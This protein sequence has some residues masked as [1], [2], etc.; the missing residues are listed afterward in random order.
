MSDNTNTVPSNHN[1]RLPGH[2]L[3]ANEYKQLKA[4]RG[5]GRWLQVL[6]FIP[7]IIGL[8]LIIFVFATNI[9]SAF[10]WFAI[11]S[12][13]RG[14]SSGELFPVDEVS[15]DDVIRHELRARGMS[16]EEIDTFFAD[17][18][19]FADYAT[20][21]A[22]AWEGLVAEALERD[23]TRL[24][25]ENNFFVERAN[26]DLEDTFAN[27][28]TIVAA[29]EPLRDTSAASSSLAEIQAALE[30]LSFPEID[31]LSEQAAT[32][33]SLLSNTWQDAKNENIAQYTEALGAI[34]EQANTLLDSTALSNLSTLRSSYKLAPLINSDNLGRFVDAAQ[35]VAD[36][37]LFSSSATLNIPLQRFIEEVHIIR[38]QF[39]DL[40]DDAKAKLPSNIQENIATFLALPA[41]QED[42]A[43]ET[44]H[45]LFN[46]LQLLAAK[47]SG[48]LEAFFSGFVVQDGKLTVSNPSS[49]LTSGRYR[50]AVMSHYR[51]NWQPLV[52]EYGL[53]QG[54]SEAEMEQ[55]IAT[56]ATDFKLSRAG[57][58][59]NFLDWSALYRYEQTLE[60]VSQERIDEQLIN[61][62]NFA[63]FNDRNRIEK[64]YVPAGQNKEGEEAREAGWY[65][66]VH[67]QRD[68]IVKRSIAPYT[69]GRSG[70]RHEELL[71]IARANDD[72]AVYMNPQLD[73]S[74]LS[75]KNSRQALMAGFYNAIIGTLWVIS[76]VI[77]FSSVLGIG[78]ALY[79][80]EYA[81]KNWFS[82]FLEVNLRNLAGVPSIVYGI[83]GL[84]IFVRAVGFGQ[85]VISAALT[86]TL[87]ILPVVII[88]SREAIRAVPDSLRQA[89]YGL[90]ATK[91]QTVSQAV[92][93]NAIPGIVTGVILAVARAI[94]ET[95]PLLLVGG[96]GFTAAVPG[97]WDA[98]F[99]SFSVM[100]L[101]I[102]SFYSMPNR[103][104]FL[105]AAAAGILVLLTILIII[106]IAAFIIRARY[107][108]K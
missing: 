37:A 15:K 97:G 20:N 23:S 61:G 72:V 67:T 17:G 101:Q 6:S 98:I 103:N 50:S 69:A 58:I 56:V 57:S 88:A 106:Y 22:S 28:D 54:R 75:R 11:Q 105:P 82:D 73:M 86:L 24:T 49:F 93:P 85:S 59:K 107:A 30:A 1:E 55:D 26:R 36:D 42:G 44:Q 80:E 19:A 33:I 94:G 108:R 60:G 40:S 65:W 16:D 12:Q 32:E 48:G 35:V 13:G 46:S 52:K 39:A 10:S 99:D 70:E 43:L 77:I 7:V 64:V 8:L 5:R 45:K 71:E 89:S 53:E 76:L 25:E 84:Y 27:V 87:L 47:F 100:P 21:Y 38:K 2:L 3:T 63:Q 104:D 34:S 79:L 14:G 78:A 74:F 9:N 66:V 91:W 29:L 102:Y 95:A 92:L 96:A 18:T 51:E 62:R 41:L 83:L 81:P 90:G 31:N 68:S 4:R